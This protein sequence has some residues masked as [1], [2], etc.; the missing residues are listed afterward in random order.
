MNHLSANVRPAASLEGQSVKTKSIAFA[1]GIIGIL[2]AWWSISTL[3]YYRSFTETAEG[4]VARSDG[5][6]VVIRFHEERSS[7]A[8]HKMQF[9]SDAEYAFPLNER[10]AT[11]QVGDKVEAY[12]RPG[13]LYEARLDKA[14]SYWLPGGL[15]AVGSLLVVAAGAILL[16]TVRWKA[17]RPLEG[18]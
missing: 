12:Y 16:M 8:P 3:L 4:V 15:A 13:R 18:G 17:A 2:A 9:S 10:T 11:L 5:Q 1:I 7:P 6:E 14:F